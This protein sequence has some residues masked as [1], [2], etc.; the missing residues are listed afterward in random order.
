MLTRRVRSRAL[1]ER[2]APMVSGVGAVISLTMMLGVPT[3][4]L[5]AAPFAL[6]L[7]HQTGAARGGAVRIRAPV[8]RQWDFRF[9]SGRGI[10][11][12]DRRA[13]RHLVD[14]SRIRLNRFVGVSLC[15]GAV[16]RTGHADE[17]RVAT[18]GDHRGGVL[19]R[20]A[21]AVAGPDDAPRL[22]QT[23]GFLVVVAV[24]SVVTTIWDEVRALRGLFALLLV[25]GIV[26]LPDDVACC[27]P[28]RKPVRSANRRKRPTSPGVSRTFAS[29]R[30]RRRQSLY[31]MARSRSR[32]AATS[33]S[34]SAPSGGS[35][36]TTPTMARPRGVAATTSST[37]FAVAQ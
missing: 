16:W 21:V 19:H 20:R 28:Q 26:A 22:W 29:A 10:R 36:S 32:R 6:Y 8:R 34:F 17:P 30:L 11:V 13:A 3:L 9:C 37:G 27:G 25:L 18:A 35:P 1:I 5:I 7:L 2:S 15:L 12:R 23:I 31:P 33:S 24:V 4:L 14:V